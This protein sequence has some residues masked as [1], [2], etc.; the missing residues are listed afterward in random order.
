VAQVVNHWVEK[1]AA[2]RLSPKVLC[3][4]VTVKMV[5][6]GQ[7]GRSTAGARRDEAAWHY[8][9]CYSALPET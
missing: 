6:A 7:S 2:P 3:V 1:D 4:M 5:A 8:P 9:A